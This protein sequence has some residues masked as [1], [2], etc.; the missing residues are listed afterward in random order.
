MASLILTGC[1]STKTAVNETKV[2]VNAKKIST[3]YNVATVKKDAVN[4]TIVASAHFTS[5]SYSLINCGE[6]GGIIKKVYVKNLD[7]VKQGQLLCEL[8]TEPIEYDLK[9]AKL[10]LDIA[11]LDYDKAVADGAPQE[12]LYQFQLKLLK[13]LYN[14]SIVETQLKNAKVTASCDGQI[15]YAKVMS[16][17]EELHPDETLFSISNKSSAVLAFDVK[18]TAGAA[19]DFKIGQNVIFNYNSK[20]Y[21][22]KVVSIPSSNPKTALELDVVIKPSS[23]P[24]SFKD[25]DSVSV[26]L[27]LYNKKNVLCIPK[28]ALKDLRNHAYVQVLKD[29]IITERF[30]T[31]GLEGKDVTEVVSGLNEGDQVILD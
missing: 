17:G 2:K 31:V 18:T 10:N 29:G 23:L 7:S 19:K 4:K 26:E 15:Q 14:V 30:I 21:D 20:N 13:E 6:R 28:E 16:P 24:P 22:G 12:V 3:N 8:D 9:S 5:T 1:S 11:K 25:G 27:C